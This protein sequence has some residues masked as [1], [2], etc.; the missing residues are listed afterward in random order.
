M[1]KRINK[2]KNFGVFQDYRRSGDIRDFEEKNIIYGWNY[3]GKTT[4]SRLISYLDKDVVIDDEYKDV[5]FEVELEDG[6]K[7]DNNNRISSSLQIKVFNSDFIRDNLHFDSSDKKINGIKFAVGD[8][9]TILEQIEKIDNYITKAKTIIARNQS[10]IYA[11]NDFETHFTN[12]AR[13]LTDLLGLGRGFTKANV[14]NYVQVFAGQPLK[15]FV[16]SD[17]VELKRILTNATTQNTGSLI[18]TSNSPSTQYETLYN[19]VKTILKRQPQTSMDDELL[20]SD[21]DLYTWA[22]SG[23]ELYNKK[24]PQPQRCAFCG[25]MITKEGRLA[26]LNAYFTIEA[27]FV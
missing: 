26:E 15:S 24:N 21:R 9:G 3:S 6:S 11:F 13:H 8:T 7:I 19:Q 10:N 20:S 5:E 22:K 14:R 23:L 27:S 1:I 2:I 12:E 16:I 18:D 4:L 17:E 25:G